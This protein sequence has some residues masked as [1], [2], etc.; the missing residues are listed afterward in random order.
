MLSFVMWLCSKCYPY[1]L[2]E[3]FHLYR[4][5]LFTKWIRHFIGHVGQNSMIGY[6]CRLW[7]GGQKQIIIGDDTIIQR[8]TILGCWTKYHEQSFSP[9]ITIGNQ[10]NIGEYSHITAIN[11][12]VIGDGL[13]TGRFVLI[14]D[15]S[16]GGLSREEAVIPPVS[17]KLVSKGEVIIGNHVWIGD[18]AT[19]LAGVHIG[20]NAIVAANSVVTKDVPANSMVAGSPAII[21]K[22]I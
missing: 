16:H 19:I 12:I 18:K 20:D 1:R 22:T 10:C 3:S 6:A 11:K 8:H 9:S 5:V 4:D 2:S 7:G 14:S 21:I 15:N 13:L 17:R